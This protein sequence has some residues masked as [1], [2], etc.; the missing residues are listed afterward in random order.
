V[1]QPRVTVWVRGPQEVSSGL[2]PAA[3]HRPEPG[4]GR[5]LVRGARGYEALAA[6]DQQRQRPW[7]ALR[8]H[9]EQ[10]AGGL[11]DPLE[12]ELGQDQP[13]A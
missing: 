12:F 13:A 5:R 11:L 9:L 7:P 6:P 8:Q 1:G 2:E 10:E 3:E 4:Q